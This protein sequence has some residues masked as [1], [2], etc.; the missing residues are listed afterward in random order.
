[1]QIDLFSIPIFVGNIDCSKIDLNNI[2]F[3]KTWHSETLSSHNFNN[4]LDKNSS[5]YLLNK[6]SQMLSHNIRVPHQIYLKNIWENRYS[7]DFQE[8]H[9]HPHSH[10]SFVIYKKIKES[11]TV[12]FNGVSNLISSFYD[13]FFLTKTNFFTTEFNPECTENQIIIFP[14]FL[15]HMVKKTNDGI[16]ISG[17]IIIEIK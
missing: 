10:F 4:T 16:T 14:S 9:I 1:V 15:E 7:D 13:E 6:I 8:K 17:N 2:K 3:E 11:K 5:Y 12:F